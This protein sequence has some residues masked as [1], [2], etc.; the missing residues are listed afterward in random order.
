MGSDAG[1]ERKIAFR[2]IGNLY[3]ELSPLVL[4]IVI[5]P[6]EEESYLLRVACDTTPNRWV[7]FAVLVAAGEDDLRLGTFARKD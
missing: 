2:D 3:N 5:V 6:S 7:R 4:A 1:S